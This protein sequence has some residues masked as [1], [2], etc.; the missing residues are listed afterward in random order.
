MIRSISCGSNGAHI[1]DICSLTTIEQSHTF[2]TNYITHKSYCKQT[3]FL[4]YNNINGYLLLK[5]WIANFRN[6]FAIQILF[7]KN[8]KNCNMFTHQ[9]PSV[10]KHEHILFA[11][12]LGTSEKNHKNSCFYKTVFIFLIYLVFSFQFAIEH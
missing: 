10:N 12:K 1:L 2:H 7:S 5:F 11:P 4:N 8:F 9:P 3:H 6:S